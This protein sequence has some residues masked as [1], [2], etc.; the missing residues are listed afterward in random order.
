MKVCMI[1]G[2]GLLGSQ[3]AAELILRGHQVK[4]I[5]LP[6]L[7]QGAVLPPEMEIEYGNYLEMSDDEIRK[8]F[9]GCEALFLRQALMKE[10]KV[11]HR[12][13]I[14]IKNIISTLFTD[15]LKLQRNAV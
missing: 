11:L 3:G 8:M 10:L 7:P 1:G 4:A 9:D 2:T 6:P 12:F 13:I 14:F 15:C 5:A